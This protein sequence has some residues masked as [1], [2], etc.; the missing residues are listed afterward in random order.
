VGRETISEEVRSAEEI[1]ENNPAFGSEQ[2]KKLADGDDGSLTG[3]FWSGFAAAKATAGTVATA[4]NTKL[5]EAGAKEYLDTAKTTGAGLV[6]GA[7]VLAST[8]L[9]SGKSGFKRASVVI[10][11]GL[12]S[13]IGVKDSAVGAASEVYEHGTRAPVL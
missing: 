8:A 13:V 1:M 7:G 2:E 5:E 11:P 10:Q 6:G 12:D 4:A 3:L 9:E